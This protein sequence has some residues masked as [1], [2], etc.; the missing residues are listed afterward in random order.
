MEFKVKNKVDK[1]VVM[2]TAN[3]ERYSD[4]VVGLNNTMDNL[5]ASL[6]KNVA[7][8][9]PSTMY[10]I[11]CVTEGYLSSMVAPR[12]LSCQVCTYLAF[13]DLNNEMSML[14]HLLT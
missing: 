14:F 13:L 6:A 1:V 7:K 8:I 10:A 5:M 9:S 11:A 12:T 3:T 4:V 2:W